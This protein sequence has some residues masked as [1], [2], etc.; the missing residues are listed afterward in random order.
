MLL[1]KASGTVLFSQWLVAILV[2]LVLSLTVPAALAKALS[3]EE[4]EQLWEQ[5]LR[6]ERYEAIFFSSRYSSPSVSDFTKE[7]ELSVRDARESY[8]W[9]LLSPISGGGG[10]HIDGKLEAEVA[11][12]D[13]LLQLY[14]KA[15]S[16]WSPGFLIIWEAGYDPKQYPQW[17]F[18]IILRGASNRR[19]IQK[20]KSVFLSPG[21]VLPTF[22][23]KGHSI[24]ELVGQR[25]PRGEIRYDA[26]RHVAVMQILGVHRPISVEIPLAQPLSPAQERGR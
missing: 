17:E 12:Q 21:D 26:A 13:G 10:W 4:T 22:D 7:K 19:Q 3:R 16:K 9:G 23:E 14:S 5:L 6:D 15:T 11:I 2:G 8:L 1:K 25:V 24:K 18:R 20:L